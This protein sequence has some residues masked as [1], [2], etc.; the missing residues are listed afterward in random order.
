VC[1]SE[2]VLDQSSHVV[3]EGHT[4]D[5]HDVLLIVGY[6][7]GKHEN[8]SGFEMLIDNVLKVPK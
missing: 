1:W 6:C 5:K 7:L 4:L 8:R 2:F 3:W